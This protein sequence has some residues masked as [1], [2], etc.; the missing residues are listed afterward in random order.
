MI[1]RF[2]KKKFVEIAGSHEEAVKYRTPIY[3]VGAS[4]AECVIFRI[5]DN[6]GITSHIFPDL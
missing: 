5:Y 4:V 6:T 3:L 2:W 1:D